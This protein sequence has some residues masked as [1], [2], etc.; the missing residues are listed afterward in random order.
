MPTWHQQKAGYPPLGPGYI[1]ESDGVNQMRSRMTFGE[2]KGQA[3][4]CLANY[5]KNQP[6]LSHIL[7]FNGNPF[8]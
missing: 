7:Y 3:M 5:R 8:A 1:M 4:E 2:N 6:N